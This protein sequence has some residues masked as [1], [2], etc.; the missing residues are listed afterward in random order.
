MSHQPTTTTR[1]SAPSPP[2]PPPEPRRRSAAL[3]TLGL[4][5]VAVG[6]VVLLEML[7]VDLPL[8][9]VGPVTLVL[10]GVGVVVSAARREPAGGALTLA[11]VLGLVLAVGSL[12]TAVLDAPLRGGVGDRTHAP[13]R[14][15][16]LAD[17]Y[18][19]VA[20][21]LTVDL[22][23]LDL[24]PGTTEVEASAVLGEVEVRLP[25][26]A[27]AAVDAEI[28][29]G[30]ATVLGTQ[31]DGLAV[32]NEQRTDDYATAQRRLL[33]RIDVGLGQARVD[34]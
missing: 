16:D 29:A 6:T 34:R 19:V 28:A 1:P 30:T 23:G 33:V 17:D 25:A 22:R 7:G 31:I 24:P 20:G 3:I 10:L 12:T 4:G 32:D 21:K 8:R 2:P 9:L 27:A 11:V 18:R 15:T 14:I 13:E 5:L 26:G